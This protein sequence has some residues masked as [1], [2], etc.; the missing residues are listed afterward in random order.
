MSEQTNLDGKKR[1]EFVKQIHEKARKNIERRTEQYTKQAN[2]GRI[3]VVFKP[4]DLVW[5]HMRKECFSSQRKS[6]LMPRGEGPFRVLEQINNNAYKIKLPGGYGVSP[7][8]NVADFS[9]FDADDEQDLRTNPFE[10]EENDE[11]ITRT[12]DRPHSN[13][14][15]E[16]QVQGPLTRA[17][18][19][20]LQA[21]FVRMIQGEFRNRLIKHIS[22]PNITP[23]PTN[24]KGPMFKPTNLI[25]L[26]ESPKEEMM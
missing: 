21:A 19:K 11:D 24:N 8:F 3:E 16:L 20:R 15:E 18:V 7:T 12:Q 22:G 14:Q 5:V 26:L 10:E 1:A 6:K 13:V 25:R 23:S 2:K 9:P 17:R 4:R